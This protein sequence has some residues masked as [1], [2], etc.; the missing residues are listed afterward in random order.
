[1]DVKGSKGTK[2]IKIAFLA[3]T[4]PTGGAENVTL[5]LFGNIDRQRFDVRFF[6]LKGPGT[7][8]D[9][10]SNL[11]FEQTTHLQRFRFDPLVVPRLVL[12]LRAFSPHIL[13]M[14]NCHRNAMLWGGM[15][16]LLAR[17]PVRIIATHHTGTHRGPRNYADID[18]LF[19]WSTTKI[20][21][22]SQ[23]HADYI[24]DVDGIDAAKIHIIANGIH[25]S[26]YGAVDEDAAG[27]LR[28]SL[29]LGPENRVVI[30]VAGLRPEKAHDAL[31]R[32]AS[33][34]V[35]WDTNL[36]FLIV[37][38]GPLRVPLEETAARL[39]VGE[40]V[41]FLGERS[42]IATLLHAS[43]V[44]VL[45]SRPVVETLP[46]S[47]MEAMAAGVPAIASSV[48]SVPDMIMDGENGRLIPPADAP[49]LAAAI[50]DILEDRA[51][52]D[53]IRE[54][55]RRTVT[56]RFT[57]SRMVAQYEDLFEQLALGAEGGALEGAAAYDDSSRG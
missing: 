14:L 45:P 22:L 49:A 53:R 13:F 12:A 50:R 8:G 17:V 9:R 28:R 1:M 46:L 11:G 34:L 4:L 35:P 41:L 7:I 5:N 18:R 55:A 21:A 23:R 51:A 32:A 16:A 40:H 6:Y 24:R 2:R 42:D 10:L 38:D 26:P 27:R 31:L 43:D 48:G 15:G 47:V 44:F 52:T 29:G 57:V 19:L 37:G 36:R 30:M 56:E 39:G 33:E 3:S 20:L 54:N 25:T